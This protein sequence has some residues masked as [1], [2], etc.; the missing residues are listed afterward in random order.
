[1]K[2]IVFDFGGV[3]IDWNPRYLYQ[4]VFASTDE[5]EGFLGQICTP[6]WNAQLDTGRTFAECAALLKKEHPEYSAQ[7]EFYFSRWEEMLGGAI[8]GTP[9]ILTDL[10]A[11]G[12]RVFGLTNWSAETF[13]I[14]YKRFGFLHLLDGIV[15]SGDEKLA[16]PGA[17]IFEVLL[18]R[19]GLNAPNCV[20]IDDSAQ[21]I[22]TARQLGF[23]T[24][25]FTDATRLVKELS[26][27]GI[28]TLS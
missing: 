22:S 24:I 26:A 16:K 23:E 19:F 2:D 18:K 11:R 1:M 21:N 6:Q 28:E 13:P 4:K 14:T 17:E 9:E 15:V 7:I 12:Y 27:L 25:V 5:M 8:Q 20:F 10:K 3:L